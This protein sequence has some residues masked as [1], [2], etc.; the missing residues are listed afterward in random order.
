MTPQKWYKGFLYQSNYYHHSFW[1]FLSELIPHTFKLRCCFSLNWL[2]FPTILIFINPVK[3]ILQETHV[4]F[5]TGAKFIRG[6]NYF[7]LWS[8]PLFRSF[9]EH[10]SLIFKTK[11]TF[12]L[13]RFTFSYKEKREAYWL[14]ISFILTWEA[15]ETIE[16][17]NV[18][19][20]F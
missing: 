2:L 19:A 8:D 10:S 16:T 5:Q 1:T 13:V 17:H 20:R 12:T 7:A 6:W 4:K 18:I 15:H 3:F 9:T 14:Y 11:I